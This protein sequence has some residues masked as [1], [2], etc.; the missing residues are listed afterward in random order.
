MRMGNE[1]TE[2]FPSKQ[3]R[4]TRLR[5]RKFAAR[6]GISK[7]TMGNVLAANQEQKE[8]EWRKTRARTENRAEIMELFKNKREGLRDASIAKLRTK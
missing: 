4:Q 1:K 3:K 6:S 8:A 5:S 2:T 7:Q